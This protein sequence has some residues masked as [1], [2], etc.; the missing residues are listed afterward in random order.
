MGTHPI[1][2][3]DFDCLTEMG[4]RKAASAVGAAVLSG[5]T[6]YFGATRLLGDPREKARES[7]MSDKVA[8]R[9]HFCSE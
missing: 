4:S 5:V 7:F 8:V 6:C 2:E 1:F 3:S 9:I